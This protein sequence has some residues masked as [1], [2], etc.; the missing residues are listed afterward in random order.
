M[1][2]KSDDLV[3]LLGA[4]ASV[5]ATIP[6]SGTM[7]DKIETLL[8]E[9]DD[10]KSYLELYH[11]LKSSIYFSAGIK[12]QFKDSVLY[13]IETLVNTLHELERN[14]AH[15]LY[16]FIATWN[17]RFVALAGK[18]FEHISSFRRLILRQLKAWVLLEE[19]EDA[20][21]YEG[22]KRLQKQ[23]NFPLKMF[24]LN[25]DLCVE[26]Q[27]N[28]DDFRVESGF[29]GVGLS[30]PWDYLRFD[31][32]QAEH[33]EP[34]VYLYK[35]HGS[36]DWK[37]DSKKNIVRLAHTESI[38]PEEMEVIF[39]RDFKLE[40]AD[41]YLFFAYE[42]RRWTLDS[43]I[44]IS[45][46]YGFGDDHIN[47]MLS[48]A[49]REEPTRRLVV[50]ARCLAEK[51]EAKR[52]EVRRQINKSVDGTEANQIIVIPGSAKEF[53]SREDLPDLIEQWIPEIPNVPF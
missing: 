42:F 26:Y 16:P 10:W 12:G 39:G 11:H 28:N 15:P 43:K 50:V 19:P 33:I 34:A 4:G 36:I 53:L 47:K 2:I 14:E 49:L 52:E 22:F 51:I 21:Y 13:N 6:A 7:V 45:I 20:A 29:P 30:K 37:R 1:S 23:L 41:P 24:S 46:G 5:E 40:A 9:D 44:I 25:Y 32:K 8:Q 38:K 18:K 17:S 35:L 27:H 48:Q 3:F 31:D